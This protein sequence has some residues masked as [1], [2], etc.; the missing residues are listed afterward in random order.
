MRSKR[1]WRLCVCGCVYACV[2]VWKMC[3]H[4]CVYVCAYVFRTIFTAATWLGEDVGWRTTG[5]IVDSFAVSAEMMPKVN[6]GNVLLGP[7]GFSPHSL[8]SCGGPIFSLPQK[9]INH[10]LPPHKCRFYIQSIFQIFAHADLRAETSILPHF[11]TINS[12][13]MMYRFKCSLDL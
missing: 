4:G 3:V 13:L 1:D 10:F 6:V 8:A 2:G 9:N 12:D 7:G 5:L 11:C